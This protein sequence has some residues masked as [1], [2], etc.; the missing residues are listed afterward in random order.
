MLNAEWEEKGECRSP[1]IHHSSFIIHHSPRPRR[2]LSLLE[3][4]VSMGILTLGV[5]GVAMLIPIGKFAM[6][7]VEKSD[8][9]G[10]CGRAGLR[11]VKVRRMLDTSN[12]L[13][14]NPRPAISPSS[15]R[16]DRN[17]S[18]AFGTTTVGGTESTAG[19]YHADGTTITGVDA[20]S[21]PL[22]G[23]SELR[24]GQGQP[25]PTNGDR[26]MLG[27]GGIHRRFFLVPYRGGLAERG[28]GGHT[29]VPGHALAPEAAVLHLRRRLLEKG[30]LASTATTEPAGRTN[31]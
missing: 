12:W 20:E 19:G 14:T 18:T 25:S 15:I 27:G 17:F 24:V 2:G 23:R 22:A 30:F 11:D 26:P 10:M 21:F 3:V 9:T 31:P 8:R 16:W 7:E 13:P 4:L 6:T 1:A 28:P 5:L 29:L